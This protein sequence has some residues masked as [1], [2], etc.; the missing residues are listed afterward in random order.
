MQIAHIFK[1]S[2]NSANAGAAYRKKDANGNANGVQKRLL[3]AKKKKCKS[4]KKV[5]MDVWVYAVAASILRLTISPTKAVY[6][7]T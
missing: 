3:I 6:G 7:G 1:F 2:A 4:M 5:Q